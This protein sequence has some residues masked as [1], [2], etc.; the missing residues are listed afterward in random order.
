MKK[1]ILLVAL[2][3]IGCDAIKQSNQQDSKETVNSATYYKDN[4]TQLC[5]AQLT[6]R[7]DFTNVPC[8]PEVEKL[9]VK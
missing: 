4:R 7:L 9:L 1:F 8:T 3:L 5:Y 6:M 2:S